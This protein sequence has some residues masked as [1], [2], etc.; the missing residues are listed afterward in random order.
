MKN[1]VKIVAPI[2][3]RNWTELKQHLLLVQSN[4]PDLIE[5]R[6]DTLESL[7]NENQLI[8]FI[9]LIKEHTTLPLLATFRTA[10]EGGD[11]E[12]SDKQY[13]ELLL[14]LCQNPVISFLDIE[15]RINKDEILPII[16]RAQHNKIKVITSYHNFDCTPTNDE[17]YHKI[18]RMLEVKTDIAK[19][20]VMPRNASDILRL[21]T[22]SCDISQ[23]ID[24]KLVTMAMGNLG[25][26]TR[27]TP[28]L[29]HSFLTF[30]ALDEQSASAPG[31][32][33][34]DQAR[35]IIKELN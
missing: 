15:V 24:P 12:I 22:F 3:G 21:M 14:A 33:Q 10:T 23:K 20:A 25:K 11:L 19:L 29:T 9:Q 17:L 1:K 18:S 27:V 13:I 34:I 31:Q 2:I 32:L 26:V 35:K 6:I 4:K 5:W 8:K 28:E 7:P 16:E 30:A